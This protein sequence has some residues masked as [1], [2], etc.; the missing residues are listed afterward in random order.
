[1]T[2]DL[3]AAANRLAEVLH[4]E[5]TALSALDLSAAAGLVADKQLALEAFVQAQVAVDQP[6][7]APIPLHAAARL[8]DLANEN[9]RL[10][11]RA[12]AVQSRVIGIVARSV[13]HDRNPLYAST[14]A[15][16]RAGRP[17][18]FTLSARA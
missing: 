4:Q 6:G 7:E 10:L 15:L 14:G 11:G 18:A 5:N 8:K 2:H 3:A 13:P 1:M 17:I 12:I 9:R 16:T